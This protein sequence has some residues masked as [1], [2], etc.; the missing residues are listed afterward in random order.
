MT[1]KGKDMS[2]YEMIKHD[3][4]KDKE[5]ID[6]HKPRADKNSHDNVMQYYEIL[7]NNIMFSA[8]G[9]SQKLRKI[10]ITSRYN[11]EGVTT[12]ASQLAISLAKLSKDPIL[13]IDANFEKPGSMEVFN[14]KPQKGLGELLQNEGVA[15][16][17]IKKSSISSL[18]VIPATRIDSGHIDFV[19]FPS[20]LSKLE[21]HFKYIIIDLPS[22]ERSRKSVLEISRIVDG[23]ILVIESERVRWEV[24]ESMKTQLL[25]AEANI[26]GVILNKRKYYIPKIIYKLL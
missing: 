24:A 22:F 14:I 6:A 26:L 23:L 15:E 16:N 20:L 3:D 17:C 13:Y 2:E 9:S 25:K 5:L 12:V 10:A 8:N 18:F 4:D 1:I 7:M 19:N 21:K 11:G